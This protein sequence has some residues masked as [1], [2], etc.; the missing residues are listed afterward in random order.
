MDFNN[1]GMFEQN[2][3]FDTM[4]FK[5]KFNF[6]IVKLIFVERMGYQD[7]YV[8]PFMLNYNHDVAN[9]LSDIIEQNVRVGNINL[10]PMDVGT[11]VPDIIE[12]SK[13]PV[14]KAEIENGWSTKR[15][16]FYMIV[17][18]P[19]NAYSRVYYYIQGYTSHYGIG[20]GGA[21]DPNMKLYF[22]NIVKLMETVQPN[23]TKSV[24]VLTHLTLV[25]KPDGSTNWQYGNL[26][27]EMIV[28]RPEDLLISISQDNVLEGTTG[29]ATAVNNLDN[30]PVS[31]D[32]SDFVPSRFI[33]KTIG[34]VLFGATETKN[35][36][37]D[38]FDTASSRARTLTGIRSMY[39]INFIKAINDY[40]GIYDTYYTTPSVLEKVD[41]NVNN[42]DVVQVL[43]RG[44][45]E[46]QQTNVPSI[47]Q[48]QD[49]EDLS[50][51]S[52][53][54]KIA[55]E[56]VES[57]SSLLTEHMLTRITF[58]INN[59][60]GIPEGTVMTAESFIPGLNLLLYG[61][62][63]LEKFKTEVFPNITYNNQAPVDILADINLVG[64]STVVL[65]FNGNPQVVYRFPMFADGLFN[66][67]LTNKQGFQEL[68]SNLRQIVN[69]TGITA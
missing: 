17:E 46:R 33:S 24:K 41:P 69:A 25:H 19:V 14:F 34:S 48:T 64:D 16:S 30:A 12:V 61:N 13:I 35:N 10:N 55:T 49:T 40:Q 27:E 37:A 8:R 3:G 53:E 38:P 58:T 65:S 29:Y 9:R 42:P 22:N 57:V 36:Y 6:K 11:A 60:M 20:T 66:P 45:M 59:L 50:R 52:E 21:I 43:E 63:V 18:E 4:S 39:D 32:K 1:S 31:V 23:G 54:N 62:R 5:P 68:K 2:N 26:Q 15:A 7:Q 47:L 56:I 44:V 67:L 51:V 28:A